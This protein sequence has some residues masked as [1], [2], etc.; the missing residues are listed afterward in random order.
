MWATSRVFLIDHYVLWGV[1]PHPSILFY[2]KSGSLWKL[3]IL[4][5]F[6]T[7]WQGWDLNLVSFDCQTLSYPLPLNF[8]WKQSSLTVTCL[9]D[10]ACLPLF[11]SAPWG[12]T[13]MPGKLWWPHFS[14]KIT[15][16]CALLF[17]PGTVLKSIA[18]FIST[19]SA[20]A[21]R[22]GWFQSPVCWAYPSPHWPLLSPSS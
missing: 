6:C 21:S 10:G 5:S 16:G 1:C 7:E 9:P 22:A 2:R 17:L 8:P 19:W 18:L 15:L 4:T 12:L 13:L 11:P 14:K 20:S 3:N